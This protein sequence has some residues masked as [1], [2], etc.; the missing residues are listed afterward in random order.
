MIRVSNSSVTSHSSGH[1]LGQP[2]LVRNEA[3]YPGTQNCCYINSSVQ[4][5]SVSGLGEYFKTVFPAVHSVG[6]SPQDCPTA[7]ALA[8]LFKEQGANT[9]SAAELRRCVGFIKG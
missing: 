5:L 1:N 7:R 8:S 4:L 9:Q 2:L 3:K 6:A